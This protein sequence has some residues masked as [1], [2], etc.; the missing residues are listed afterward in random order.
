MISIGDRMKLIRGSESRPQFKQRMGVSLTA[1]V[2][3]ET[4][5]RSPT[6]DYLIR[7]LGLFPDVSPAWLLL[8]EGEMYRENN[9][10]I[11]PKTSIHKEQEIILRLLSVAG[12]ID[13]IIATITNKPFAGGAE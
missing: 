11:I 9:P 13:Q 5:L 6:A 4:G 3:Y 1:V 2:N 7:F 8:G 10:A 12:N